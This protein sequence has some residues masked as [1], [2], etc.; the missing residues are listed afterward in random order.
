MDK[1]SSVMI[2]IRVST[3]VN[4]VLMGKAGKR[5]LTVS[6]LVKSVVEDFVKSEMAS[7]YRHYDPQRHS[8]YE[9]G[10]KV[11][12]GWGKGRRL[13]TVPDLDADGNNIP[14]ES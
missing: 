1:E 4:K 10:E 12:V 5:G 11:W 7:Q 9:V 3:E 13:E 6:A 14:K 2:G 8:D